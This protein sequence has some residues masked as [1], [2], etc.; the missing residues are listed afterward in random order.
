MQKLQSRILLPNM[1]LMADYG[2]D[3]DDEVLDVAN[4]RK[5]S[6]EKSQFK[7]KKLLDLSF[8][9]PSIQEALMKGTSS[10]DSDDDEAPPKV[11]SDVPNVYIKGQVFTG[12][13]D[14]LLRL[15]PPV[16][17]DILHNQHDNSPS[18]HD[19]KISKS[20][21]C[22]LKEGTTTSYEK[23]NALSEPM[24]KVK[25][26]ESINHADI[27]SPIDWSQ[28]R[29]KMVGVASTNQLYGNEYTSGNSGDVTVNRKRK[30]REIELQIQSGNLTSLEGVS[31]H[32]VQNSH[33]WDALSY[34]DK[35][36]KE[37]QIMNEYTNNGTM[38][39][40]VQP[41]KLQNRRHQLS[42]LALHAAETEIA[43]MEARYQKSK[44]KS[45][46]QSKYGW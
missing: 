44:S 27:P 12:E 7:K 36:N 39:S 28:F 16:K 19:V 23:S 2:S 29:T 40:I 13:D 15:L 8:L 45:Q 17:K 25:D 9:P 10:V 32:E 21:F 4:A 35:Q 24:L 14:P 11:Q 30:E 5:S 3:K 1:D 33:Q 22:P 37:I 41:T 31:L 18:Q 26:R 43:M 38:K 34:M 46:T 20:I 6:P 42:S